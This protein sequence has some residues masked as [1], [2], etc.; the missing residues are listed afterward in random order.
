[1]NL[2][3]PLHKALRER[4]ETLACVSGNR[5]LRHADLHGRVVRLAAGLQRLGLRSGGCVGM[6]ALNSDRYL[7]YFYGTL[8]AGG[9]INPVNIRWSP[10][11]MAF[12]LDDCDT[13]I[14]LVDDTH[15]PLVAPVRER[16]KSLATVIHV[17]DAPT[18][19]SIIS[20][21]E[22]LG[23]SA[24]AEDAGRGGDDLAAVLYTGGTTG[25]P[26]GVMLSHDNFALNA[27][28][29][30]SVTDRGFGPVALHCAPLFHVAGLSFLVQL[31][32]RMGMQVF[33]PTFDPREVLQLIQQEGITETFMV[34]TMI[35]RLLETQDF[36][37][38]DLSS[39]RKLLYGAAP[40]DPGL[41]VRLQQRLPG[42]ELVQLYGQTEAGPV[43][44][45]LNPQDHRIVSG[46]TSKL[47]SAGRPIAGVEVRI[48]DAKD[49]DVAQGQ[50]GEVCVRGAGT[51]QGYLHQPELTREALRGGW[52]H[53][54]DLGYLDPDGYLFIVDRIK[55]MII[56]GGEN[57]YSAE[58]ER[59]L[60]RHPEVSQCAVI[61]VADEQW[62]ERVHAVVVLRSGGTVTPVQLMEHCRQWIAGYKCPRSIEYREELPTSAAGKLLKHML[63]APKLS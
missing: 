50:V 6:L 14:L 48:V 47:S 22:L 1:M 56:T 25:N 5:R 42:A 12:A 10:H 16:S 21:E 59:A 49:H 32:L 33:M 62:G 55:D 18:P 29:G 39:L 24:P 30:L 11:E 60:L 31:S 57:V 35:H 15:L 26:K 41:Q 17:G 8:W 28:C 38:F 63:R 46:R 61:G 58:V 44:S 54:G 3:Q 2:T 40:I 43:V 4:P 7:E 53:S 23:S 51:M 19:A 13:H 20:C 34:P 36:E 45:A 37:R 52:L 9:V 27:L